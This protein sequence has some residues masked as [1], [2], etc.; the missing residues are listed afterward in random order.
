VSPLPERKPGLPVFAAQREGR[1]IPNVVDDP[2]CLRATISGREGL[3]AAFAFPILLGNEVLGVIDRGIRQP[4]QDLL[5]MVAAIGSQIGQF[6]ERRV[7][8]MRC[9]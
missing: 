1:F 9:L 6:I 7:R 3:N 2:T 8:K 4:D 5:D